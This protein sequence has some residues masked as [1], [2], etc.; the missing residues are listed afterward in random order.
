MNIFARPVI[1][2]ICDLNKKGKSNSIALLVCKT[3]ESD[4]KSF[5]FRMCIALLRNQFYI[6][7]VKLATPSG[8]KH[9]YATLLLATADLPAKAMVAN[10]K[11]FNGENGCSTWLDTGETVGTSHL[12]RIWPYNPS[13]VHRI[14]QSVV[15]CAYQATKQGNAVMFL[16]ISVTFPVTDK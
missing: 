15:K 4:S 13:M 16:I 14:H 8:A 1:N 3:N 5:S 2:S 10:M 7:G 6:A 11:Q 9:V 12:H